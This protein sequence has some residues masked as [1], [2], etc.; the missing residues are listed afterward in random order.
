MLLHLIWRV[1][2]SWI[3]GKS[4]FISL[5]VHG[6]TR[7]LKKKQPFADFKLFRIQLWA[8]EGATGTKQK[9]SIQVWVKVDPFMRETTLKAKLKIANVLNLVKI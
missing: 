5:I 3:G 2:L 4:S 8:S 9:C 1:L 7:L 6:N